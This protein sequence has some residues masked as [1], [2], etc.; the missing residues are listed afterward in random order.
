MTSAEHSVTQV[1]SVQFLSF[2]ELQKKIVKISSKHPS[3]WGNCELAENCMVTVLQRWI[4]SHFL[5]YSY[6]V[7]KFNVLQTVLRAGQKNV[8]LPV[9]NLNAAHGGPV[10]GKGK[11]KVFSVQAVEA[12]RVA[13]G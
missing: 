4:A 2:T 8:F 12:F 7:T 9:S 13:R 10:T 5:K 3:M 11:G 6:D 1:E